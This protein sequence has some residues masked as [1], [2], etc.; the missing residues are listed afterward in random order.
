MGSHM[1]FVEVSVSYFNSVF[2]NN[3]YFVLMAFEN[4]HINQLY[5]VHELRNLLRQKIWNSNKLDFW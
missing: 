4:G 5:E 3:H 2:A 1:L